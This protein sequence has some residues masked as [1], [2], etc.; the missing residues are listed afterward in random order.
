MLNNATAVLAAMPFSNSFLRYSSAGCLAT[1]FGLEISPE[2]TID[3]AGKACCETK[4][5]TVINA[6]TALHVW[7]NLRMTL[8]WT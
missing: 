4:V 3:V 6:K 1:L 2:A 7:H 5:T 8:R